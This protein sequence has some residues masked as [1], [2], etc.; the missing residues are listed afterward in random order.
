MTLPNEPHPL[1]LSGIRVLDLGRRL[2]GPVCG[3]HLGDFGAEVIKVEIPD[4]G[5]LRRR[6]RPAEHI[7][8]LNP[9]FAV[10]NRN[11]KSVTLDL[12]GRQGQGLLKQLVGLADV[13]IENFRPGMLERWHLGFEELSRVNAG[14]ILARISAYG[15]TGPYAVRVGEA[16]TTAAFGGHVYVNGYPDGPP[17]RL[18]MAYGDHFGALFALYGIMMALRVRDHTG[19]GQ[20]IDVSLAEALTRVT[21]GL[22]SAYGAHGIVRGRRGNTDPA[23]P[24]VGIFLAGDGLYVAVDA[25]DDRHF[26]RWAERMGRP[27][28]A[29]SPAYHHVKDRVEHVEEITEMVTGW[30][31]SRPSKEVVEALQE[32][33]IPCDVVNTVKELFENAH[34]RERGAV[35]PVDTAASGPIYMPGL[36]PHLSETPGRIN[37]FSLDLGEHNGEVYEGLLGLSGQ[38]LQAL[39]AEAVI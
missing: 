35:V 29:G 19:R 2:A 24:A 18:G 23:Q 32:M 26:A 34:L 37:A 6:S 5:D 9:D 36:L 13:V 28:I 20:E 27:D 39:K 7:D 1:P 4:G 22:L 31:V 15:Q 25:G 14:I 38:Q 30:I 33:G 3:T 8:G 10:D 17:T 11:K 12:H 16:T 21:G